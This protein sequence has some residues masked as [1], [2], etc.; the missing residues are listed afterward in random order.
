MELLSHLAQSAT[1]LDIGLWIA[2]VQKNVVYCYD[3]IT[4]VVGIIFFVAEYVPK[5]FPQQQE[6]EETKK[7][8]A[9]D[10]GDANPLRE[11]TL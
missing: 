4:V 3:G 9:D 7:S 10:A 6:E 8:T 11:T 5:A 2:I 1:S